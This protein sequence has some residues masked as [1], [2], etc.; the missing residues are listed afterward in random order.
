MSQ[1]VLV[2]EVGEQGF[3]R[4]V[5]ENSHKLPVLVEFMA[6]WSGP[7][8]LM[9]DVLADLAEEFAGQF[10]FA[11]VD[12]DE[13]QGLRDQYEIKNVPTLLVMQNGEVELTQ[14]GQMQE[15][16]LRILLRGL[17]VFRESDEL[18]AQARSQHMAGNTQEAVMLLTQA[19]QQD[20]GNTRVA[21]DMVQIF[22]DMGELEQATGLFNKLPDR[23]KQS[24]MGKSLVG[25]L[26]FADLAAKTSGIESLTKQLA[27]NEDDHDAR[28]DL[29]VCLVSKHDYNAAV[30]HLFTLLQSAQD[31]KEGA[32]KEMIITI[33]NMLAPNDPEQAQSYR[34]RL[35]NLMS[36]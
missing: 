35:S 26:T 32:A 12:V 17:G 19:I 11:K 28:F 25:Q 29:A 13:Q 20:P 8:V 10:V 31:Y 4:Y 27:Q 3:S 18:R 2:F 22:I 36:Q 6:V 24:D 33:S 1:D 14:E 34:R 23:D 16:E 7:C 21:M 15:D 5:I 30:E 9:A